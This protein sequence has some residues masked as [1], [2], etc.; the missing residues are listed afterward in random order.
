MSLIL[1]IVP[2][3]KIRNLDKEN[4]AAGAT[5]LLGRVLSAVVGYGTLLSCLGWV[6]GG[7]R[8]WVFI[9]YLHLSKGYLSIANR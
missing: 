2:S 5:A 4:G 7:W 8:I 1:R 9:G 3:A 6:H